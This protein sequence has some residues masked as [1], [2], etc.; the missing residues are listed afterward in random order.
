MNN[1]W[2]DSESGSSESPGAVHLR[3]SPAMISGI[4]LERDVNLLQV[5]LASRLLLAP[6]AISVEPQYIVLRIKSSATTTSSSMSEKPAGPAC[7]RPSRH[8]PAIE[9]PARYRLD[10]TPNPPP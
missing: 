4:D 6:A 8:K 1:A 3:K 5:A 2:D 9:P 7:K 10:V